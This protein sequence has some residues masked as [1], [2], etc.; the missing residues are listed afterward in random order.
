MLLSGFSLLAGFNLT[1]DIIRGA[2]RP[3]PSRVLLQGLQLA[4]LSISQVH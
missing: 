4:F 1:C 3:A 2:L